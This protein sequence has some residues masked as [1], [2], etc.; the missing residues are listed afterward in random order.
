MDK[1]LNLTFVIMDSWSRPVY[2]DDNG[3]LYVD[4]DP[5]CVYPDI[6]TKSSNEIDGEPEWPVSAD[7]EITFIPSRTTWF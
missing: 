5:G 3:R 7:T 4:A 6:H 1:K 2:K